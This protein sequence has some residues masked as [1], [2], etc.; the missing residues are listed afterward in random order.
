M[1]IRAYVQQKGC[2]EAVVAGGGLLG[3]EAAY[4]LYEL[5]LHVTVLER[6]P[7]LLS[8]Q[9]DSRCS[10]LVHNY[11]DGIGMRVLYGA[12]T[13]ALQGNGGLDSAVDSALLKDGREVPCQVFLGAIG[14][15]P[16]VDLAKQAGISVN[17]GVLVDDRMATSVP[18][19]FA[20]GDVAEHNGLVLGLWPIAA[21]QGEVAAIN[22]LGGDER[23]VAEVPACILK[24]AGIELSSIGRVE[25]EPGDELVVIDN[26][27]RQSYR[28]MVISDGRL[29]G[30]LVLGHHP[31]DFS[32]ILAA[33]KKG[34]YVG[35]ASLAALR[36]GDMKALKGSGAPQPAS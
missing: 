15:R 12:E 11:F 4:S 2:R 33:V 25:P 18:G 7:R 32:S 28:R 1:A 34:T 14:I 5:G 27:S 9:I 31:E 35:D 23:L 36:A 22:A 26:P 19:I 6:G 20:A 30:G 10:E 13:E 24:G 8:R 21:K 16:N 29:V 3:L 17:R